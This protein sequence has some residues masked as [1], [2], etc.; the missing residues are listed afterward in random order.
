MKVNYYMLF[1]NMHVIPEML[2]V[3]STL[4]ERIQQKRI[5]VDIYTSIENYVILWLTLKS[6]IKIPQRKIKIHQ[7]SNKYT[8]LARQYNH[9]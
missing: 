4:G 6:K 5:F 2:K 9:R 3:K 8:L 1:L 7:G